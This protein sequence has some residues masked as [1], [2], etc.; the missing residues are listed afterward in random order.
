MSTGTNRV[1]Q[2]Q[3]QD[4]DVRQSTAGESADQNGI[5]ENSQSP[6]G[7][8]KPGDQTAP[9]T[10]PKHN[11]T[12]RKRILYVLSLLLVGVAIGG[13]W[14]WFAQA[15]AGEGKRT[16]PPEP[17]AERG[18]LEQQ[19][20]GLQDELDAVRQRLDEIEKTDQPPTE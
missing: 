6:S 14:W 8:Q 11:R 2:K 9:S 4:T 3:S 18:F 12:R 20:R 19:A 13:G 17:A 7:G 1:D 15:G 5:S 16:N 10:V